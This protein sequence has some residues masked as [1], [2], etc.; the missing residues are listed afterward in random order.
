MQ[1]TKPMN[2]WGQDDI[3]NFQRLRYD[4]VKE[5]GAGKLELDLMVNESAGGD[6]PHCGKAWRAVKVKND[7]ADYTYYEP[8]CECYQ[9]CGR[10]GKSLH[11]V[12]LPN[13]ERYRCPSCGFTGVEVWTYTCAVCGMAHHTEEGK[14]HAWVCPSCK[15]KSRKT[16]R[17]ALE[18]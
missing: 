14:Y 4:R 1:K 11:G 12:T 17:Q 7:F 9:R 3:L 13:S 5:A 16:K 15:G 6:C 18:I 10:C 2:F 8:V